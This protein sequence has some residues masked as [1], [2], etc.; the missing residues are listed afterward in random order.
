[1]YGDKPSY[2]RDSKPAYGDKPSYNR[3]SK[4]AYGD[5]PSSS[6]EGKPAYNDRKPSFGR[7]S[8][9]AYSGKPS[10]NRDSK[11]SYGEKPS[12]NRD[13]REEYSHDEKEEYD[14]NHKS[15]DRAV[16]KSADKGR[17]KSP[18]SPDRVYMAPG[19]C[20]YSRECGACNILQQPY[21]S[22]LKSKQY[23]V[24]DL[25]KKYCNVSPI[26]G[27]EE[28]KHYRNKV[29]VVFDH[30][31]KGN[32]VSGN[33]EQV[34]HRV[35]PIENCMI[36]NAKADAIIATIR[37]LLPS[38]KIKTY[39]EDSNYGLFRHVLIRTG[40]KSNEI[41]VVL[42]L[43]S[44]I[45]PSKNNFV[46]ALRQI[47]PEITT[48]VVNVNDKKTSM[49]LGNK[50]QVIYGKGFIEDSL[51]DKVFRI[52][53]KS[54]YQVN[55]L[56]TEVVYNKA[57]EMAGLTGK[58]TVVDAYCGI[59][60]IGIIASDHAFKV[61][62]VELSKDA[63]H[64]AHINAKRN[65]ATNIEFYNNDAGEFM[66]QMAEANETVD[67][68]FMDPPRTGSNEQ[69]MDALAELKPKKVVYVSCNP[70][71]LER[72][73]EYMTK[74]GFK[75]EKAVPVDMF[76]WTSHVETVVLMSKKA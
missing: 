71:T 16:K 37:T 50:E 58:E 44:P 3:D 2:N 22:E 46:K 47:H 74:K 42:V 5:K 20:I 69:F 33:Y 67:V 10:Y 63:V 53:P 23:M 30:D 51:C 72:D 13:N 24:E 27:M 55:P 45:L 18:Y 60:T 39:D 29:H 57:I 19:S 31:K 9:P 14:N 38:F 59:G 15:E 21:E 6:R 25:I 12:Y 48:V 52:S 43:A 73:L 4:P 35:V 7:D 75:V 68:V 64:D 36:H 76:P 11:P 49:I 61:I 26:I 32:P 56:Q 17:K 34:S 8:K 28:P 62:G 70:T 54:F 41:M 65:E 40:Y 66:M 1:A